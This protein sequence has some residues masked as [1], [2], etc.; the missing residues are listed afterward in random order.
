MLQPFP[1]GR[2]GAVMVFERGQIAA[3][4]RLDA[5]F[6]E[7][8]VLGVAFEFSEKDQNLA[9]V[10]PSRC[11]RLRDPLVRVEFLIDRFCPPDN[12]TGG[13]A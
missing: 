3:R 2:L 13:S 8:V 1:G 12:Q 9:R 11:M 7:T 6:I 10:R 4:L 5:S